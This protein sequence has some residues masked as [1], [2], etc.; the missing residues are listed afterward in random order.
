MNR[1][2]ISKL[3]REAGFHNWYSDPSRE[4]HFGCVVK[5]AELVAAA[6]RKECAKACDS[7]KE[8]A[9]TLMEHLITLIPQNT[10]ECAPLRPQQ[11][12]SEAA[13]PQV[14]AAKHKTK[15]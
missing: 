5:F 8:T 13:A 11:N 2:D 3:A 1:D 6:E 4:Y 9:E 10:R 12:E 7:M 15:E 14:P